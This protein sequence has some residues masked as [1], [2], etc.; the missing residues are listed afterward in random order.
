MFLPGFHTIFMQPV[1]AV[2]KAEVSLIRVVCGF[3]VLFIEVFSLNHRLGNF[4]A[5]PIASGN[6]YRDFT[7]KFLK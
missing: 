5:G 1:K 4:V 7:L 6:I 3:L 2:I